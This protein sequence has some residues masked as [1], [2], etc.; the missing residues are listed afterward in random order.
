MATEL[1]IAKEQ[2]DRNGVDIPKCEQLLQEISPISAKYEIIFYLAATGL[3]SAGEIADKFN[4][5]RKNINSDFAKKLGKYLKL[6][7]GLEEEGER[8]GVTSLRRFLFKKNYLKENSKAHILSSHHQ[9][10]S[11][12]GSEGV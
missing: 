8:V 4:H 5:S 11:D 6:Y 10:N 7:F 2:A 9:E 12:L 3:Y 1:E